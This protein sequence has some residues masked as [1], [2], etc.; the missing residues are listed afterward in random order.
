MISNPNLTKI[1]AKRMF[2][3]AASDIEDLLVQLSR[4][5]LT[6]FA[7]KNTVKT[8]LEDKNI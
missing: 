6:Y 7:E 3:E 2:Y 4:E 8:D 5:G 1:K